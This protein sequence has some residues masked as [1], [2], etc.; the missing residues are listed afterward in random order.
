M[1][2]YSSGFDPP[3]MTHREHCTSYSSYTDIFIELLELCTYIVFETL[4]LCNFIVRNHTNA[5]LSDEG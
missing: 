5:A 2:M 4:F 1:L 3:D